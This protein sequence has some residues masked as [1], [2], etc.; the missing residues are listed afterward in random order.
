[1]SLPCGP[2][3]D[4]IGGCCCEYAQV[5]GLHLEGVQLRQ[6]R[7]KVVDDALVAVI[8]RRVDPTCSTPSVTTAQSHAVRVVCG[9]CAPWEL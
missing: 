1:M 2:K 9:L 3:S 4:R 5:E 7:E 8:E 6:L